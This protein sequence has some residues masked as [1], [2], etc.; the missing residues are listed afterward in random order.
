MRGLTSQDSVESMI[1]EQVGT[2][3]LRELT[4]RNI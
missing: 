3:N 1:V 2:L 4:M